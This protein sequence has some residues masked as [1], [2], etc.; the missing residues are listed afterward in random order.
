[1]RPNMGSLDRIIRA[2]AGLALLAFALGLIFPGTGWNWLGWIGV[3]LIITAAVRV[4]PAYT[5]IGVRTGS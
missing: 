4:C 1:M 2:I 3:V 5:L